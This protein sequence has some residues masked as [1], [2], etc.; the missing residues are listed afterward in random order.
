MKNIRKLL[1]SWMTGER[2]V[3][4]FCPVSAVLEH[5]DEFPALYNIKWL[6]FFKGHYYFKTSDPTASHIA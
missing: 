1:S 2:R 3:P 5:Y 4:Y 6:A